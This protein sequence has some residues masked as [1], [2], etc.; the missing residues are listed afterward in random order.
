MG[1]WVVLLSTSHRC[2]DL[3]Q[4]ASVSM[5]KCADWV[6]LK[7][8]YSLLVTL[9]KILRKMLK[10][11]FK[12]SKPKLCCHSTY[13]VGVRLVAGW[14]HVG[15]RLVAGWCQ[16]GVR[17]VS[18]RWCQV[19]GRL[20]AG[21][22]Q[23]GGRLV[24]GWCQVGVR[25]VA[26]WCQV[27]VRL[28]AGWIGVVLALLSLLVFHLWG[29]SFVSHQ[30]PL[31][32]ADINGLSLYTQSLPIY[33]GFFF[34]EYKFVFCLGLRAKPSSFWRI[35]S[36]ITTNIYWQ[37]IYNYHD[38]WLSPPNKDIDKIGRPPM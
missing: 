8:V 4:R 17:L 18:G 9:Y 11:H 22:C 37:N 21:W 3:T 27:G 10:P 14:W 12:I 23:V 34:A 19:G 20:V 1:A 36:F 38:F 28:V 33:V 31:S 13:H 26:G 29:P 7:F 15:V 25:L 5:R 6:N 24:A 16:V 35:R 2:C 30:D 32:S